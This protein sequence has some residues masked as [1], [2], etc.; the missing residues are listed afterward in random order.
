MDLS[1]FHSWSLEDRA[2]AV[3][4]RGTFLGTAAQ[5]GYTHALYHLDGFFCE[6]WYC[7]VSS[8]IK[9]ALGFTDSRMLEPYL[10]DIELP[11]F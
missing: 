4:K 8:E 9:L 5:D 11:Y 3:R 10:K 2:A 6:L 7:P 1:E